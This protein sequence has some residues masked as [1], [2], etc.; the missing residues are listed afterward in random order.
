[1]SNSE[2]KLR[3]NLGLKCRSTITDCKE[4]Y[5]QCL[6]I[7]KVN[8]K[9]STDICDKNSVNCGTEDEPTGVCYPSSVKAGYIEKLE[10]I[11][12]ETIK[13]EKAQ[14]KKREEDKKKM[15][16]MVKLFAAIGVGTIV[17]IVLGKWAYRT[18]NKIKNSSSS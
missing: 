13:R 11:D 3:T 14:K 10:Y 8:G 16:E 6:K 17:V 2:N 5:L 15:E 18:V 4:P 7:E 12:E 1:M 9:T